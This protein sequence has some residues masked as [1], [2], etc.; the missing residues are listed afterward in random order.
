VSARLAHG[1][2]S[3]PG[4]VAFD[5]CGGT[6]C[7]GRGRDPLLVSSQVE[8]DHV[9]RG[10]EE[11]R[12]APWSCPV[13]TGIVIGVDGTSSKA[14]GDH[15]PTA[16][17]DYPVSTAAFCWVDPKP[18]QAEGPPCR[19][20]R[21][22]SPRTP[23]HVTVSIG[24]GRRALCRIPRSRSP[25]GPRAGADGAA[26]IARGYGVVRTTIRCT[27]Q[28]VAVRA[29]RWYRRLPTTRRVERLEYTS[30]RHH[31]A[32]HAVG[33]SKVE[34]IVVLSLERHGA[35]GLAPSACALCFMERSTFMGD[36]HRIDPPRSFVSSQ[37]LSHCLTVPLHGTLFPSPPTPGAKHTTPLEFR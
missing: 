19:A 35:K 9:P 29:T 11:I 23:R 25:D 20:H 5:F 30:R 26:W 3:G 15:V 18:S 27:L 31:P 6:K 1:E 22:H 12:C 16:V 10:R 13:W 8:G 2:A 33:T 36:T 7:W 14:A 28:R 34:R 17:G 37:S 24:I 32:E 4:V 21:T